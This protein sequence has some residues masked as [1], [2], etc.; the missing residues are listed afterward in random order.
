MWRMVMMFVFM[1]SGRICPKARLIIVSVASVL[2][3][4]AACV[5]SFYMTMQFILRNG[6]R[7]GT[8]KLWCR[9]VVAIALDMLFILEWVG[10]VKLWCGSIIVQK[11]RQR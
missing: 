4:H 5:K 6:E 2:H 10:V 3:D 7:R 11:Y 8:G 1:L 9:Y